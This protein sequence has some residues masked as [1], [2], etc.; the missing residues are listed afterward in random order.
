MT[1]SMETMIS[2]L[3]LA[4][5]SSAGAQVLSKKRQQNWGTK[6]ASLPFSRAHPEPP[7]LVCSQR[8]GQV[9]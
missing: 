6:E 1:L 9:C 7:K 8:P 2:V 3:A 4:L 5:E